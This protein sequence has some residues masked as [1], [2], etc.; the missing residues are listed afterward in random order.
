MT[1]PS[2]R[3]REVF[4]TFLER[5]Y[6]EEKKA[7]F[8]ALCRE[9]P[10]LEQDLR[11]LYAEWRLVSDMLDRLA[12][13]SLHERLRR[14]YGDEVDLPPSLAEEA[15][16]SEAA[17]RPDPDRLGHGRYRLTDE[18]ARGGMGAVLKVW[19]EDLRRSLAMKIILQEQ[20]TVD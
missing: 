15:P 6:Q 7:D 14:R 18:I 12:P 3:A 2:A 17:P 20:S 4:R 1:A 11:H 19:D 16:S 8:E 10:E 5:W 13:R 9:Q